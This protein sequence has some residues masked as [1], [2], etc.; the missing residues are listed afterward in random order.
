[1]K[2]LQIATVVALMSCLVVAQEY[3]R[4]HEYSK[5]D[6]T[7]NPKIAHSRVVMAI[8]KT[9]P[10]QERNS[11]ILLLLDKSGRELKMSQYITCLYGKSIYGNNPDGYICGGEDDAGRIWMRSDISISFPKEYKLN[12]DIEQDRTREIARAA[13]DLKRGIT[14]AKASS[15][16][17]PLYVEKLYDPTRSTEHG[18]EPLL[19]VCYDSKQSSKQQILYSGCF[20]SPKSCLAIGKQH[21]GH[22]EN[23]ESSYRAFLRCSDSQP[24]AKH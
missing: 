24:R 19:N 7:L 16:E 4:C 6:F 8:P 9:W 13:M 5:G 14:S 15:V 20:M 10:K 17:C 1:M 3:Y 22:Y 21:F 11:L 12:V 2:I 23:P 18:D